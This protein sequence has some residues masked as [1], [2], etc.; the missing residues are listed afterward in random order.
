MKPGA[1]LDV[2][3]CVGGDLHYLARD[4]TGFRRLM[5]DHLATELGEGLSEDAPSQDAA[6]V[7]VLAY[8]ADYLSYYQDAV[9]T[10]AYLATARQR[11][12][13]ARHARL[14]G[15]RL[16]E[17]CSARTW[18]QI[19]TTAD[20]VPVPSGTALITRIPGVE[21]ATVP[22]SYASEDREVFET[23][24][25]ILLTRAHNRMELAQPSLE[26]GADCAMLAGA[27]PELVPGA[28]L[29]LRHAQEAWCHAV[30]LT[31]AEAAGGST[32]VCW[33]AED[34]I[35]ADAPSSGRW[36][37][38]GNVV[39]ADHG[40]SVE[41]RLPHGTF[42]SVEQHLSVPCA[43]LSYAVRYH[44][45]DAVGRSAAAALAQR[46]DAAEPMIEMHETIGSLHSAA[47]RRRLPWTGARDLI[48]AGPDER[49]FVVEV[50]DR[51]HIRLRFGDGVHGRRPQPDWRHHLRYR[52]GRGTRGNV[53]PGTLAHIAIGDDRIV[54][55][56]NPMAATGG[57]DPE[58]LEHAR[59]AA[60]VGGG[61]GYRCV[62]DEDYVAAVNRLAGV[63]AA[64]ARRSRSKGSGVVTVRVARRDGRKVEEPFLARVS[65]HLAPLQLIG[66]EVEIR[67]ASYVAPE[68]GIELQIASGHS[69]RAVTH[70]V[71]SRLAEDLRLGFGEGLTPARLLAAALAIPGVADARVTVLARAGPTGTVE[72]IEAGSDEIIRIDPDRLTLTVR[73]GR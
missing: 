33:H 61:E 39:L 58:T 11:V 42:G 64:S 3:A 44:H 4:Y 57:A 50:H 26:P 5:L 14:L 46:P 8:V 43:E 66:D 16:S 36:I 6:L 53:G 30:R 38:L 28:V 51:G 40:R 25:P 52:T 69:S 19:E 41:R 45:E 29:I 22:H 7:E 65:A 71:R 68:I 17:G 63:G 32:A 20:D 12:S 59:M 55:V 10:E 24:H 70:G 27:L 21:T 35:P 18:V 47:G 56:S 73:Y 1:A 23:M 67:A 60:V 9:A 13:V 2:G 34:E 15:Y 31:R 48:H 37:V 62:T 54:G 72:R 49:R